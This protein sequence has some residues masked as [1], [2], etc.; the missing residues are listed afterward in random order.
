MNGTSTTVIASNDKVRDLL[1][2]ITVTDS[3]EL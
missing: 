1:R 2:Q 3:R